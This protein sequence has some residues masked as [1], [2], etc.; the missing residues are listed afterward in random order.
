MFI[1]NKQYHEKYS[2]SISK[3]TVFKIFFPF[4]LTCYVRDNQNV[5]CERRQH[6]REECKV[7][8][9]EP[10][11]SDNCNRQVFFHP[12]FLHLSVQDYIIE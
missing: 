10:Y 9:V 3:E 6:E 12:L 5:C 8:I 7:D 11:L 1:K 4:H 2:E